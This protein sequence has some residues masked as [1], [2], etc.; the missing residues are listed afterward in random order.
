MTR[1][2]FRTATMAGCKGPNISNH[3]T[4][5]LLSLRSYYDSGRN[6]SNKEGRAG[7]SRHKPD[8]KKG[9]QEQSSWG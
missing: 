8:G 4:S 3:R 2:M 7:C 6:S 5:I 9:Q 1:D